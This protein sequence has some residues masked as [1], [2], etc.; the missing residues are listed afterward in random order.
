MKKHFYIAVII[1]LS[2]ALGYSVNNIAISDTTPKVAVIDAAKIVAN[3]TAVKN[4]KAEQEKKVKEIQATL[5]KAKAELSKETDPSKIAAIEEKYRNQV[6]AQKI[7]LDTEYN[8]KL[9]QI[10][11]E[12]RSTV[13]EKA[14]NLNYDLVLPKNMVYFGG[15]DITDVIA[16][17]IK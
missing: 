1:G 17:D 7:A 14:R 11:N 10:D 9:T 3:S 6:N 15:D 12:I 5:D 4:L 2:F 8:N 13:V 16:K